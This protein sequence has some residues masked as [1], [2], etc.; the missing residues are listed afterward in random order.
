[1]TVIN[2]YV[3]LIYTE[4]IKIMKNNPPRTSEYLMIGR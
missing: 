1:M 2:G 3:F 4:L